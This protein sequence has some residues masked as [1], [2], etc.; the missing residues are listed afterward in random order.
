M[1]RSG[2]TQYISDSLKLNLNASGMK[3]LSGESFITPRRLGKLKQ[4]MLLLPASVADGKGQD[5][6]LYGEVFK[7]DRYRRIMYAMFLNPKTLETFSV[8]L[9]FDH[10]RLMWFK[11]IPPPPT[12]IKLPGTPRLAIESTPKLQEEK[13]EEDQRESSQALVVVA[14]IVPK[15]VACSP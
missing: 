1:V 7:V 3:T 6:S 10:P 2:N 15:K 8:E 4:Q 12:P 5:F 14:P 9:P 13:K 11:Y